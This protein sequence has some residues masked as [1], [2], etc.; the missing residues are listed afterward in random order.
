MHPERTVLAMIFL[1]AAAGCLWGA[2][3]LFRRPGSGAGRSLGGVACGLGGVFFAGW[4]FN[5]LG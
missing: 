4:A 1:A 2:A 3:A 5:L